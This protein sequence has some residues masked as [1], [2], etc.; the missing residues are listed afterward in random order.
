MEDGHPTAW[1]VIEVGLRQ[2]CILS[3]IL[4][5]L[6]INDLRNAVNNLKKGIMVCNRRISILLFADDVVILAENKEDLE[7]MLKI[8]YQ[9]SLNW[10]FCFNLDKCGVIS[11]RFRR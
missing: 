9:Y 1:F 6:F 3:P 4:F 10:R 7:F 11:I 5:A 2:G 8:V